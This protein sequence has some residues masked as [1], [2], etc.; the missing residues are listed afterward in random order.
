[1]KKINEKDKKRR[2][3]TLVEMVMVVTILGILS[4]VALVKYEKAQKNAQ[5]NA[6]YITA[7]NIAT[8]TIMALNEETITPGEG[9]N[10]DLND[11]EKN[12]YLSIVPKAQSSKNDFV[13]KVD[14]IDE[15]GKKE[16]LVKVTLDEKSFY[17][18]V[19]EKNKN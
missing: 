9:G 16:D 19:I 17:P 5:L 13:V 7:S 11:L 4:S 1:M 2:G 3:F 8:A 12:G 14:K 6:D 18:K 10:I 15:N